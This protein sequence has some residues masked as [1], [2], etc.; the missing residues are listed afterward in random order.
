VRRALAALLEV[1]E[2]FPF[3]TVAHRSTWV[4][5][6]LTP[7][8]RHAFEGPTPLFLY[9]SNVPGAGKGVLFDVLAMIVTGRLAPRMTAPDRDEEFRKRITSLAIGGDQLVLLDNIAG[10]LG[11]ASLDAALTSTVWKDRILGRSETIEMP[12]YATWFATGNNVVLRADT[13]RRTAHVRLESQ[14]ERPEE[15]GG[16][17]HP[18]LRAWV[19]RERGRLLAA[20]LTILRGYC[21]AGRPDQKL[22]PWGSFE[23]WS[24]LVRSA[25]VWAGLPDP[26]DTRQEMRQCSDGDHA[27]LRA[28]LAGLEFLETFHGD[29]EFLNEYAPPR[30]EPRGWSVSRL[31]ATLAREVG[32]G[33]GAPEMIGIWEALQAMCP[34]GHWPHSPP[35]KSIGMKLHHLRG[36]VVDGRCLERRE[37]NH[38]SEWFVRRADAPSLT[39]AGAP[40]PSAPAT[41]TPADGDAATQPAHGD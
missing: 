6:L 20:A 4:A 28:I 33:A 2:D 18:D 35:L 26:G 41:G 38:M 39:G 19:R 10:A 37:K 5:S 30:L 36:R 21:A 9:D 25:V 27:G 31:M 1:V 11:C 14:E 32:V 22:P 8:A 7:L 34:G 29:W 17:R 15:R 40:E 13:A 12:L 16:F 3:A 23:G 24:A